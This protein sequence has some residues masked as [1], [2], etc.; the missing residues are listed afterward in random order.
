MNTWLRLCGALVLCVSCSPE[1]DTPTADPLRPLLVRDSIVLER[2]HNCKGT[3]DDCGGV[4]IRFPV[5]DSGEAN[6]AQWLNF[7]IRNF[8]VDQ[9]GGVPTTPP[10]HDQINNFG[11]PNIIEAARLL[12]ADFAEEKSTYPMSK[13]V[14]T[15]QGEAKVIAMDSIVCVRLD[16]FSYLGGAHPNT[17]T[18]FLMVRYDDGKL[19]TITDL[20][21]NIK[22]FTD[23]VER[24]FKHSVGMTDDDYGAKGYYIKSGQFPLPEA[25]GITADSIILYYNAFEIA[26]YVVGATQVTLPRSA[27]SIK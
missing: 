26:P 2:P 7:Y 15:V 24:A 11:L 4:E 18:D 17:R 9:C 20:V 19:V 27:L 13:A 8:F 1:P 23:S 6:T 5:F 16:A 14:W 21:T 22:A 25:C 10:P 12:M 3:L